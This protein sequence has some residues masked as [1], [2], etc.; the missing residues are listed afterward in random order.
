VTISGG[1]PFDQAE[2]LLS[3]LQKMAQTPD[4]LVYTGYGKEKILREHSS[5]TKYIAALVDGE[6]RLGLP[7]EAA[8]KG[9]ENQTLTVFRGE[10][11]ARYESWATERKGSS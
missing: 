11:A 5:V 10:F 6:F 8:W 7:A 2:G 4:V 1:E 9:S 3:L